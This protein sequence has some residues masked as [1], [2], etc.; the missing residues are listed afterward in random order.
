[1]SVLKEIWLILMLEAA[2]PFQKKE[3]A[4]HTALR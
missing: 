3:T 4:L 2:S 1:M